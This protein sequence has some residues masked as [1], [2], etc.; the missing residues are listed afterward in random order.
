MN[1]A[2]PDGMNDGR[3]DADAAS[4][5]ADGS[6]TGRDGGTDARPDGSMTGPSC[7]D[8]ESATYTECYDE[9]DIDPETC[10]GLLAARF[11]EVTSIRGAI[12]A[13][14][15]RGSDYLMCSFVEPDPDGVYARYLSSPP[16]LA[17]LYLFSYLEVR[18]FDSTGELSATDR[19]VIYDALLSALDLTYYCSVY[20]PGVEATF[21]TMTAD[22]LITFLGGEGQSWADKLEGEQLNAVQNFLYSE[23]VENLSVY[24]IPLPSRMCDGST[25]FSDA[26]MFWVWNRT[27]KHALV[28]TFNHTYES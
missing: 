16:A 4:D 2:R 19:I 27:T 14:C 22:Q 17:D 1:D 13:C 9:E 3:V 23:G 25:Y 21:E 6:D 10:L 20:P 5:A 26:K 7:D 12:E 15:V 24:A 11:P 28:A 18:N 8:I